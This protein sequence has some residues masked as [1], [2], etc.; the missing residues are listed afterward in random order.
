MG[1]CEHW[2]ADGTFS[3]LPH[4]INQLNTI[5]GVNYSNVVPT[6]YILLSTKK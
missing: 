4:I 2:L 5:H 3:C 6:A 1:I